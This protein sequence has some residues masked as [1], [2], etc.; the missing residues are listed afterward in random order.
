MACLA[1]MNAEAPVRMALKQADAGELLSAD[2][3]VREAP[4]V[5]ALRSLPGALKAAVIKRYAPG[6]AVFTQGDEGRALVVVLSGA[7]KLLSRR[8]TESA[9]VGTA[10]PGDVVGEV[11]VLSGATRRSS[12]AVAQGSVEVVELP[13][14]ALLAGGALP[15]ALSRELT[16]VQ[17]RRAKKLDEMNDFLNRW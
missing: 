17:Q 13:R 12:S 5:R 4:V 6:V 15:A 14:E 1:L 2:E 3:G 8:G 9:E 11:E 7:V 16:V 10:G